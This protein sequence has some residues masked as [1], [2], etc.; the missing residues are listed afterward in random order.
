M[1]FAKAVFL[2]PKPI[3]SK[4]MAIAK[5]RPPINAVSDRG[6]LFGGYNML[7]IMN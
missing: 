1:C 6:F 2:F 5:W 4:Q 3:P 7:P